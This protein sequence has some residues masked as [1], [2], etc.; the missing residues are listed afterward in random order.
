[1]ITIDTLKFNSKK[2]KVIAH[3]GLSGLETE[4]TY[5]AFVAA[6]NRSYFGIETDVHK[7][8]DGKFVIIH[9]NTTSRV[10][11]EKINIDV[12]KSDF[13][14]IR[15]IILPDKDGS[16][17]RRDI[18]IPLLKDYIKICKKYEKIAVLELK[19]HFSKEDIQNLIKEI[20]EEAYLENMIFISFSLDN[21]LI[22][23]EILPNSKIQWILGGYNDE[24]FFEIAV[25]NRLDL[26]VRYTSLNTKIIKKLHNAGLEVNCWTCN[27]KKDAE[28]LVKMGVDYITTNILE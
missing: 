8:A 1:M 18:R 9:D 7:T 6:G 28:K 17:H 12:E 10:T 26:D 20:N 5:P 4:N 19:N 11:G 13:N 21:C 3:R 23:R 22:L 16:F 2:V 24:K 14:A 27:N 15:D 25:E